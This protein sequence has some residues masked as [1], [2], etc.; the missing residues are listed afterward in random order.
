MNDLPRVADANSGLFRRVKV[1]KFPDLREDQRNPSI[2]N[3]IAHEGAGILNWALEG[4]ERLRD[5]GY[6]KIPESVQDAT[7]HFQETNDVPATF[8]EE[9]C[10]RNKDEREQASTLYKE[11]KFWCEENGHRPFSSTRIAPEWERLGFTKQ[12]SGGRRYYRGLRLRLPN[13]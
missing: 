6:F 13:E 4:L 8:V 12:E 1:V 7:K 10:I 2:K 9:K 3:A 5:R 11:Y